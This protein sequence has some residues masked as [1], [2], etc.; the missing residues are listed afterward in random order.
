ME[1][2][3][4]LVINPG[5]TSTKVA[6]FENEKEIWRESINHTTEELAKYPVIADQLEMRKACVVKALEDHGEDMKDFAAVAA[7][8]GCIVPVEMGAYEVN[9]LV[10]DIAM[11]RPGDQHPSNL[12]SVIGKQLAD[13]VGI[14]AYFYDSTM[15]DEFDEIHKMSGF[16]GI[17]RPSSGHQLNARAAALKFCEDNGLEYKEQNIIVTHLGGGITTM[18]HQHGRVVDMFMDWTGS[19]SPERSGVLPTRGAV[20]YAM[21]SGLS[22]EEVLKKFQR[23]GGMISYCGTSDMR[24]VEQMIAD[25]D[26]YAKTAYEAMALQVSKDICA[27][28]ANV[29][30]DVDGI[31]LTGG[32]AHSKMLTGMIVRRVE[33][34]HE[35]T[36]MPGE[37]EMSALACGILRVLRGEE[38]AKI[39]TE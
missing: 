15:V 34:V 32:L 37:R 13:S 16:K 7:R 38:E 31:I 35:V 27:M 2:Y 25:G 24:K 30:G 3:R 17:R 8:G 12:A 11:H 5:S 18:M 22:A 9:D 19:F 29:C 21:E 14:K 36:I 33:F 4:I 20:M 23:S 10:C 26:E 39:L 6:V 28:A 1:T